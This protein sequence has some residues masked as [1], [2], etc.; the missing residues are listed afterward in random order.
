M[1]SKRRKRGPGDAAGGGTAPAG[2]EKST[3]HIESAEDYQGRSF[4]LPP[5]DIPGV[6]FSVESL[7]Q[8]CFVPK[9]LL[10]DWSQ[11]HSRGVASIRLFPGY[12]ICLIWLPRDVFSLSLCNLIFCCILLNFTQFSS[13]EKRSFAALVT[14]SCQLEWTAK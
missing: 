1:K 10:H 6:N 5:K 9:R 4:I 14:C 7:P 12:C 13:I 3:L 11:A 8:K 2:D